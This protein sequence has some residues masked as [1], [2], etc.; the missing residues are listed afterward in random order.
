MT[1]Y[2]TACVCQVHYLN[3]RPEGDTSGVRL[4]MTAEHRPFLAGMLMYASAFAI[5]PGRPSTEVPNRCCMSGFEPA[6]GFAFRVHTHML[7]A[8]LAPARPNHP[9]EQSL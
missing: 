6:H 1:P 4:S 8:A 9:S 3:G 2:L 5:P 7:G